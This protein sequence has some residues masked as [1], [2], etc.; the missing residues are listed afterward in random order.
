[1]KTIHVPYQVIDTQ[2]SMPVLG[3]PDRCAC[4][5]S[6][7]PGSKVALQHDARYQAQQTGTNSVTITKYPLVWQVP[8]C[9]TCS[10]HSKRLDVDIPVYLAA[11]LIWAGLG[12]LLFLMDLAYNTLAILGY[13][14]ALFILGYGSYALNR[15]WKRFQEQRARGMMKPGCAS[16][17]AAV[18]AR[19]D[20]NFIYFD[21]QN[22]VVA[23]EFAAL[24]KFN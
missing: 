22:E 16:S 12:Y 8:Y 17:Q 5:G 24:N 6:P 14:A 19:S 18:K 9:E 7:Q 4:C 15:W 10:K 13:V 20:W 1:M 11:F 2:L 3:W 21:F 23:D